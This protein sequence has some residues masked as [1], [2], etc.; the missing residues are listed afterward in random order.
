[1][2]LNVKPLMPS[3]QPSNFDCGCTAAV[4]LC[5]AL[6]PPRLAGRAPAAASST[7]ITFAMVDC[8]LLVFNNV[9]LMISLPIRYAIKAITRAMDE[10]RITKGKNFSFLDY[11]KTMAS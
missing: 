11:L 9:E 8:G 4:G 5:L 3:H 1:V 10:G 2:Q 6:N 7:L